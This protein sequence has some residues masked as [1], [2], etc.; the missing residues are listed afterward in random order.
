LIGLIIGVPIVAIAAFSKSRINENE[1]ADLRS[2]LK[3]LTRNVEGLHSELERLRA[4]LGV[5][6]AAMEPTNEKPSPVEP[7]GSQMP[8]APSVEAALAETAEQTA[9]DAPPA[10]ERIGE[11]DMRSVLPPAPRSSAADGESLEEVLTSRW[12][13]WVGAVSIGLAGTFLVKYAIDQGLLSPAIRCT[14]GFLLGAGLTV[15]GEWLRQRPLQRAIASIRPNHVPGALTASGLFIAFASIYAAYALY[16]LLPPLV[17]FGGLAAVALIAVGLSLLEGMFVAL[18]GVFGG[19]L[20]PAL[21]VTPNPS[22]WGLVLYLAVIEAACLAVAR[23]QAWWS[24]A[25]ATLAGSLLWCSVLAWLGVTI[26]RHPEL[27]AGSLHR[28]FALVL[29]AAVVLAALYYFFVQKPSAERSR[30]P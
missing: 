19:F 26:G 30:G 12:L 21:I 14:L 23:Y 9:R 29:G 24:F 3:G 5:P 22:A 4:Q 18:L 25:L 16:G 10:E 2:I 15:F 8:E 28:F 1:L 13:V 11:P 20:T 27:L 6:P 17:A 7:I